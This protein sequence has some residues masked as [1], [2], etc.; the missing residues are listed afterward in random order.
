MSAPKYALLFVGKSIQCRISP[1]RVSLIFS[2]A[3]FVAPHAAIPMGNGEGHGRWP[4]G[5]SVD[6]MRNANKMTVRPTSR[7]FPSPRWHWVRL[8]FLELLLLALW[9]G[10]VFAA[11]TDPKVTLNIATGTPLVV[12]LLELCKKANLALIINPSNF[13]DIKTCGVKGTLTVR[14]ALS[15]LLPL[16]ID[17]DL[18]ENILTISNHLPDSIAV[19]PKGGLGECEPRPARSPSRHKPPKDSVPPVVSDDAPMSQVTITTGSHLEIGSSVG[20]NKTL[21]RADLIAA[22]YQ[23]VGDFL[24]ADPR[25]FAG[26][27]NPGAISA[28][29]QSVIS[30]SRGSGVNLHGMGVPS[31]LT[32]VNGQRVA[33]H[34]SS[35]SVDVDAIPISAVDHIDVVTGGA[36]AVYGSDAVA[37]TVNI[38]LRTDYQGLELGGTIGGAVDGGGFL[39]HYT[40][41]NGRNW[42]SGNAFTDFDCL[43]QNAV[44]SGQRSFVP[45]DIVGTTLWPRTRRCSVV[46]TATQELS[47]RLSASLA[48]F[49]THSEND[50]SENL[51]ASSPGVAAATESVVTQYAALLTVRSRLSHDW[52]EVLTLDASADDVQNPETLYDYGN[53]V[54]SEGDRINNGLG[55]IEWD[56]LGNLPKIWTGIPHLALGAVYEQETLRFDGNTV[57]PV[58]V[59][60]PLIL[61]LQ[62]RT[63]SIFAELNIPLWPFSVASDKTERDSIL[64]LTLAGRTSWYTDVGVTTNPRV[65]VLYTPTSDIGVGASWGTA[66][67]APSMLQKFN[68]SQVTLQPVP[69]PGGSLL[70]LFEFGGNPQLRP[71]ESRDFT[72]DFSY[73]REPQSPLVLNATA[74]YVDDHKR[75]EYPT[76]DTGNPLSDPNV[77]PYVRS[78]PD[79]A[80]FKQAL[81]QSQFVNLAGASYSPDDAALIIDDRYQNIARERALGADFGV[82]YT[83]KVAQGKLKTFLDGSYLDL[84][85]QVT[86]TPASP[87]LDLSGTVFNPPLWRSRAGIDWTDHNSHAAVFVNYTGSSRNTDVA[88]SKPIA[89]WMTVDASLSYQLPEGEG[90]FANTRFTLTAQ[91]LLNRRPPFASVVQPGV[92]NPN[93][94]STNSSAVG[95]FVMLGITKTLTQ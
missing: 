58:T 64:S 87:K 2:W 92:P 82:R 71:E 60:N 88:P 38:I 40:V 65:S 8:E 17:Y 22:G 59:P 33:T 26:S 83:W 44:D 93:F 48:G 32:L 56:T 34:E 47:D 28:G 75:I 89:S 55:S 18:R 10:P 86:V 45:S 5:T 73:G 21:Y 95:C 49:Y 4:T 57:S 29:G 63:R 66:Y 11:Q 68:P 81:A 30:Q 54:K 91:N 53:P 78:N 42:G 39:Q 25:N 13:L 80:Q 15:K 9:A 74:F 67:R 62:R 85:Q 50:M 16:G 12:A 27:Q 14:P 23:T 6:L 51:G 79:A 20:S 94:D 69:V 31:T 70:S 36:S 24:R 1:T 76:T 35:D 72:L 77:L 37:G 19:R 7:R 3:R 90:W 52:T 46:L 61:D 41:L 43:T 84:R